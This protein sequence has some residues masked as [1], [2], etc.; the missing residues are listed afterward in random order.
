MKEADH[1]KEKAILLQK[2]EQLEQSLSDCKEREESQR[3][4]YDEMLNCLKTHGGA[5]LSAS[6]QVILQLQAAEKQSQGQIED[7]ASQ[8]RRLHQELEYKDMK[9][10][11]LKQLLADRELQIKELKAELDKGLSKLEKQQDLLAQERK[12]HS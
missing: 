10:K 7:L 8:R 3:R 9:E 6:S 12:E 11:E 1:S 2:I 5:D 4:F